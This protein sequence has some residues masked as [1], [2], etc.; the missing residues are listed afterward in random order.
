MPPNSFPRPGSL[1]AEIGS[2]RRNRPIISCGDGCPT[3]L[4]GGIG[5]AQNEHLLKNEIEKANRAVKLGVHGIVDNSFYGNI[6]EYH[7]ALIDNVD[8]AICTVTV[9]EFASR[10]RESCVSMKDVD[11]RVAIDVLRS[12]AERGLDIITVH[13]SYL[14]RHLE[15]VRAST[16]I[17][18]TTSKGGGIVADYMCQRKE[19]NP[20]YVN[21]DDILCIFKQNHTTLALGSTFRPATVCD[22]F[23]ELLVNE[24]TVMGELV[25]RAQSAGV[26]VMIEGIGH[27]TI[28]NIPIHIQ[29]AKKLC[30]NAPY[31]MLPMATDVALGY[32]HI[33]AAIAAAVGVAAGANLVTCVTRAEHVGLPSAA[34]IEE[35]IIAGKIAAH[36]GEISLPGASLQRD[37][38]MSSARWERGCRGDWKQAVHPIGAL[39]AL[40][41]HAGNGPEAIQCSMCGKYCGIAAAISTIEKAA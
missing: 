15:R 32:D 31:R 39:A 5:S 29:L 17:I 19:E 6:E 33:S 3:F 36:C 20:Y 18:P 10:C 8:A 16:R 30:H 28:G 4:I 23:D 9:Y 24:L 35:G 27:A 40:K 11:P 38:A 2:L 25:E 26:A 12:Q 1:I 7:K 34:D 13:A 37:M 41:S 21:F 14:F 22:A